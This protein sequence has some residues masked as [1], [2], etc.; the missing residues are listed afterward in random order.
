METQ[1]TTTEEFETREELQKEVNNFNYLEKGE[2]ID[3][4]CNLGIIT[5]TKEV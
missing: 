4:V 2:K 3:I 5:L 1:I